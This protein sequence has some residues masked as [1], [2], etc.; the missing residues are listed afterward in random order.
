MLI[1]LYNIDIFGHGKPL[2]HVFHTSAAGQFTTSSPWDRL[3]RSP[4]PPRN[5]N[6]AS[7]FSAGTHEILSVVFCSL[8]MQLKSW[9]LEAFQSWWLMSFSSWWGG[10]RQVHWV[11]ELMLLLW[12]GLLIWDT[13]VLKLFYSPVDQHGSIVPSHERKLSVDDGKQ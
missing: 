8:V 7:A 9:P 11:N 3:A 1:T 10:S 13:H 12:W 2:N 5:S 4:P 6:A